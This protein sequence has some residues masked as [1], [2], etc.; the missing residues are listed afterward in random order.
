MKKFFRYLLIALVALLF[1]GT[2]VFL[3]KKSR[4]AEI[5]YQ[6]IKK[7]VKYFNHGNASIWSSNI[8]CLSLNSNFLKFL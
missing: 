7:S 4:P 6:D 5:R 2:F 1:I 3:Y 8:I